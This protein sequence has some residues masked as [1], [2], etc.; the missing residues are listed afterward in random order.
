MLKPGSWFLK[1]LNDAKKKSGKQHKIFLPIANPHCYVDETVI[2]TKIRNLQLLSSGGS[3]VATPDCKT[4][5]PIQQSPQP[6]VDC[7]SLDALSSGMVLHYSLSSK[8]RQRRIY[9]KKMPLVYQKQ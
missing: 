1:H 5:V 7:Q 2:T 8:G 4:W 9:T 3:L 6:T